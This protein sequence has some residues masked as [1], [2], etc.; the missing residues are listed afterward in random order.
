MGDWFP[1]NSHEVKN[2]EVI[3]TSV[4]DLRTW[5]LLDIRNTSGLAEFRPE[6]LD[7]FRLPIELT[8]RLLKR[9]NMI[10]I[11][12]YSDWLN[13]KTISRT[14]WTA[15]IKWV[16]PCCRNNPGISVLAFCLIVVLTILSA[17][18]FRLLL[19]TIIN[20]N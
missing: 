12:F 16:Q 11:T 17:L 3:L 1:P 8:I 6:L 7:T 18:L 14:K 2:D 10:K 20:R 4:C 15:Y 13:I 19:K 5:P 9:K